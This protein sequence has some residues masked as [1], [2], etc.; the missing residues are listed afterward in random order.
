MDLVGSARG[1]RDGPGMHRL[2]TRA[3]GPRATNINQRTLGAHN[4]NTA[5]QRYLRLTDPS[6]SIPLSRRPSMP[7]PSPSSYRLPA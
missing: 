7:V 3:P 4:M 5:C 2:G 6:Q 1:R